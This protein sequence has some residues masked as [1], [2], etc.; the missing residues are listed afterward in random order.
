MLPAGA[1]SLTKSNADRRKRLDR[2]GPSGC[3]PTGLS[4]GS[5]SSQAH[6][7]IDATRSDAT[8]QQSAASQ[9]ERAA[10]VVRVALPSAAE[11][12]LLDDLGAGGDP[13]IEPATVTG[14]SV[15]AGALFRCMTWRARPWIGAMP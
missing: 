10:D 6:V 5:G 9:W 4:R 2:L 1:G 8:R 3:P 11:T 15:T 14:I 7:C 13:P 12:T